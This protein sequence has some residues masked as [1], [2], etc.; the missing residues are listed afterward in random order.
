MLSAGAD[1][2][3][4]T[5]AELN[6]VSVALLFFLL[7]RCGRFRSGHFLPVSLLRRT[8]FCIGVASFDDHGF[9]FLLWTGFAL[10]LVKQSAGGLR[11]SFANLALIVVGP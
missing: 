1:D 8:S 9:A 5:T 3:I 10:G 6:N 11:I 4:V 7:G 2:R